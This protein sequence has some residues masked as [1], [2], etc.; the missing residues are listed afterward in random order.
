MYSAYDITHI[1]GMMP[2]KSGCDI[3]GEFV[4][5]KIDLEQC[6]IPGV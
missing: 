2:Y 1:V 6:L 4:M 5:T 3:S